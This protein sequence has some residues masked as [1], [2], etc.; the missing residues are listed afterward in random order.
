[1]GLTDQQR[2][3]LDREF[4][5]TDVRPRNEAPVTTISRTL[6]RA[7]FEA[8]AATPEQTIGFVVACLDQIVIAWARPTS[9]ID[10]QV[11]DGVRAACRIVADAAER[12]GL[13]M[14]SQPPSEQPGQ[15]V[16]LDD[17]DLNDIPIE[18]VS[19]SLFDPPGGG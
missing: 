4:L 8:P 10:R 12:A 19:A 18:T 17:D 3:A 9:K 11:V 15:P 2:L 14:P 6:T 7:L 13:T 16:H 5:Y 1:M